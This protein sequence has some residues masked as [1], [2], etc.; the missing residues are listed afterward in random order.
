MNIQ[1]DDVSA[2]IAAAKNVLDI[3][4]TMAGLLPKG[5]ESDGTKQ[6]LIEAEKALKASEV[7]LA[8]TLGYHLCQCTFPPQIMLSTGRHPTHDEEIFKCGNCAK[9]EPSEA[10]FRSRDEANKLMDRR[11]GDWMA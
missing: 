5:P 10:H 6:R 2:Y 7:Q 9:Q 8:K 4:K 1:M 11:S 3:L